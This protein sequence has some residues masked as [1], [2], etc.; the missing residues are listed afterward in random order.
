MD[1]VIGL[2]TVLLELEKNLTWIQIVAQGL[3]SWPR[4]EDLL[5]VHRVG[6]S[7]RQTPFQLEGCG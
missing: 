6:V 4:E 3:K 5:I 7:R 2:V 1:L